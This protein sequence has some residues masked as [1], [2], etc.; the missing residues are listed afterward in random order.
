MSLGT[1]TTVTEDSNRWV[2]GSSE[3]A[4]RSRT[5]RTASGPTFSLPSSAWLV[6]SLIGSWRTSV[7]H[8][9]GASGSSGAAVA[10]RPPASATVA[11]SGR[12]D[13]PV[14]QRAVRRSRGAEVR[15]GL[16][17]Q[18][19]TTRRG[20]GDACGGG[21]LGNRFP[22]IRCALSMAARH[23]LSTTWSDQQRTER[24]CRAASTAHP[25]PATAFQTHE[26]PAPRGRGDRALAGC[27]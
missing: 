13:R 17:E 12:T 4:S 1:A 27:C 9:G 14:S 5:R 3:V 10:G 26:R 23:P 19:A 16:Q 6:N 11:I 2:D 20:G 7:V 18:A 15:T 21:D 24:T 8:G 22:K 25:S